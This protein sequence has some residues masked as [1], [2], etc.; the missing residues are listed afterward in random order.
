MD[1][2][3]IITVLDKWIIKHPFLI[4]CEKLNTSSTSCCLTQVISQV[5]WLTHSSITHQL[6]ALFYSMSSLH[7]LS[8]S[9][10]LSLRMR[11]AACSAAITIIADGLP[12]DMPGKMEA[13]TTNRL[14][15]P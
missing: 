3:Q 7:P 10:F 14:S 11:S 6:I 13:S 2:F 4:M 5:H 1:L 15:V 9:Y 12:V 8:P